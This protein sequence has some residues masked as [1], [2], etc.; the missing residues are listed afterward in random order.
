MG[1]AYHCDQIAKIT[2]TAIYLHVAMVDDQ[3]FL[4]KLKSTN[5]FDIIKT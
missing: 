2:L 1:P 4:Q 3:V 5:H